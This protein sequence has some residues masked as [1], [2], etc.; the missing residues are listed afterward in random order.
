MRAAEMNGAL[1]DLREFVRRQ[2]GGGRTD[3]QL[4]ESFLSERD[5]GAFTALVR[6]HGPMVLGV[7]R[8]VLGHAQDAEDAF[9]ATFLVLARKAAGIVPQDAVG[10]WLYG[11]AYRTAR[12]AKT[13]TARRRLKEQQFRDAHR[14]AAT[15]EDA[16]EELQPLLDDEL[17]RLPEKYR[18]AIVLCDLE[19]NTKK[20]AAARLRCPEG[21]LSSRLT[22]G[23]R[24]LAERLT[25]RGVTLP[26]GSLAVTLAPG[27]TSASV[28]AGLV[29]ATGKAATL[30]AVGQAAGA[31]SARVAILAEGVLKAMLLTKLKFALAV[32]VVAGVLGAAAALHRE[33]ARA[34]GPA[35]AKRAEPT[36]DAKPPTDRHG[37]PL[38]A[39]ALARMGTVRLRHKSTATRTVV[40]SPDSKTLFSGGN[41]GK[42][43][44][45][46]L[47]TGKP[48]RTFQRQK[49]YGNELDSLTAIALCPKG[50]V[51]AAAWAGG[52]QLW[53][54]GTA[55][56]I[57]A[58][59]EPLY[60]LAF[61]PDGRTLVCGGG[62]GAVRVWDVAA[63][64]ELRR[65]LWQKGAISYLACL[66]NGQTFITAEFSGIAGLTV[67]G[68]D[69]VTGEA[70]FHFFRGPDPPL[71]LSPD[72]KVLA[73][74]GV[75]KPGMRVLDVK[76][77]KE[78]F[79]VAEHKAGVIAVAFS[80]DGKTV[81]S[82]GP[83]E[84][85]R[86]WELATGK[87]I[88]KVT[89]REAPV[90][91]RGANARLA[92]SPDGKM[93]ASAGY[94]SIIRLWDVA[95]GKQR[96]GPEGHDGD[97]ITVA[98]AP[99]GKTLASCAHD[100]PTVRLWDSAT[101]RPLRALRHPALVGRILFSPDGQGV[102]SAC[103][104]GAI[105]VWDAVGKEVRTMRPPDPA[106]GEAWHSLSNLALTD[107]GKKVMAISIG[108]PSK[109]SGK[110]SCVTTT[111]DLATGK[112][113]S[114][115]KAVTDVLSAFS[116]DGSLLAEMAGA[117]IAVRNVATG[118]PALQ[119]GLPAGADNFWYPVVFSPSRKLLATVTSKR[120][121]DGRKSRVSYTVRVWELASGKELWS[122]P[123]PRWGRVMAFSPDGKLLA[124]AGN[125]VFAVHEATTGK[126]LLRREGFDGSVQSLA[127][128]P[129]GTRLATGLDNATVLVWDVSRAA[130]SP[131][132]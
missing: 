82:T 93:L 66:P 52:L 97:I 100:D 124:W 104:D 16:W 10:A 54:V 71:G 128:S 27:V 38:P 125:D 31:V 48:L 108:H 32:L 23:R 121:V 120:V 65:L 45:W 84:T 131:G 115:R 123:T 60:S 28:P 50:K 42:V 21:T 53:D 19:G 34:A 72:G 114:Q 101:G 55:K 25:R 88:R 105:R 85:I 62:D 5:E 112:Q 39:G 87:E 126:E 18:S 69:L 127:F 109:A 130:R 57:V 22:R 17:N 30:L 49:V 43:R 106:Q 35:G 64:K 98:F 4:L 2:E 9:Q 73:V 13:M 58:F 56:E 61:T 86:L 103:G 80:P 70:R 15:P 20:A 1:R 91:L 63:G 59:R 83:D 90:L 111:W 33:P 26:A 102:I 99:D 89:W 81:A 119:L 24:L 95:T 96:Q 129:G 37:D 74:G 47:A 79:R 113:L 132:R 41:D 6:R 40:V 14:T 118:N 29:V 107:S 94:S 75:G 44:C 8:R 36:P 51:L 76:T 116:A 77:G 122:G 3:G 92:F 46:D 117:G 68:G 67:H 12:K 110:A 11:V 7:C 78:R